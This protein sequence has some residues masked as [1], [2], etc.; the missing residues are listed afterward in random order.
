MDE[1]GLTGCPETHL[2]YDAPNDLS[3]PENMN[4]DL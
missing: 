1:L 4:D 2:S 3:T